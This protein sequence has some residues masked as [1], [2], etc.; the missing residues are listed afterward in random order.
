[1]ATPNMN[2]SLPTVSTTSGPDWATLINA[3][4]STIDTH[5]HSNGKGVKIPSS[6]LDINANLNIS[7]NIFYNFKATRYVQQSSALTGS[8]YLNA[9]HSVNGDL[10]WTN[11]SG[12][13]VQITSSGALAAVGGSADTFQSTSVNSNTTISPSDTFVC[14][15]IDTSA[16]RTINLPSASALAQGRIYIIKDQTGQSSANNITINASGLDTID[17]NANFIINSDF[18]AITLITDGIS[19]WSIL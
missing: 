17:S 11:G 8:S 18:S 9:I 7:N 10:Y 5:D 14:L 16:V 19:N 15:L 2:L 1:M 12:T 3:A 13:A 6:G 4:F